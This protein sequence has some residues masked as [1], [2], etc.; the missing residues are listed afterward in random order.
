M[1]GPLKEKDMGRVVAYCILEGC[2]NLNTLFLPISD[3]EREQIES[4]ILPHGSD[5]DD[6]LTLISSRT[7]VSPYSL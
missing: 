2:W 3:Q 6:L 5:K 7:R 4:I 1:K